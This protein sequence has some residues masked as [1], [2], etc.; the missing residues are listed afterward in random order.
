MDLIKEVRDSF[1]WISFTYVFREL[2][3][4][5]DELSKQALILQEVTL[6]EHPFRGGT[7]QSVSEV[8]LY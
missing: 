2:N 4:Q 7:L 8:P 6:T 5:D 1:E 3:S